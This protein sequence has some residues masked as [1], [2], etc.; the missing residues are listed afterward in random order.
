MQILLY[1]C[2]QLAPRLTERGYQVVQDSR[3]AEAMLYTGKVIP[4]LPVSEQGAF[5]VNVADRLL[6]RW[7]GFCKA[8]FTAISLS[9]KNIF[10]FFVTFSCKIAKNGA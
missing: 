2:N 6:R 5:L 1:G 10:D 8:G 3:K 9:L 7:I 4:N